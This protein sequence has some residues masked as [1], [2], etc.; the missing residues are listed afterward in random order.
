MDLPFF[1]MLKKLSYKPI[2]YYFGQF[3]LPEFLLAHLTADK[4]KSFIVYFNGS[5]DLLNI[6]VGNLLYIY[7]EISVE[8]IKNP[9]CYYPIYFYFFVS[10][11]EIN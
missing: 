3:I 5:M 10:L 7:E 1:Q 2:R 11:K 4:S 8:R 9:V 6:G